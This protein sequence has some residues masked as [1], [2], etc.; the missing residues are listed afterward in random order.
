M[1][2]NFYEM[3]LQK[4][5]NNLRK[6][7]VRRC[8]KELKK[9]FPCLYN[10]GKEYATDAARNMHMRTKHNEV[11]KTERD[12]KARDIIRTCGLKNNTEIIT[13]LSML[14]KQQQHQ[15]ESEL[16][17]QGKGQDKENHWDQK[18]DNWPLIWTETDK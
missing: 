15:L 4:K 11:T 8:A 17:N 13:K 14:T 9:E 16:Q 7:H 1:I 6:K 2:Q 18:V 5:E 12:K 10:C 3:R